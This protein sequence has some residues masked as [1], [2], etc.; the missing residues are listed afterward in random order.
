MFFI[1]RVFPKWVD[2]DFGDFEIIRIIAAL[3]P[4]SVRI[5]KKVANPSAVQYSP[6]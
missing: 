3:I 4:G 6:Y 5:E 1:Y 2:D